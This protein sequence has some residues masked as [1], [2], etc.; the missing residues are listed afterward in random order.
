MRS[1][2]LLITII[3]A[4]LAGIAGAAPAAWAGGTAHVYVGA[5]KCKTC[6]GKVEMGDQYGVWAKSKH[7]KAMETLR[8]TKAKEYGAKK[9]IADPSTAKECVECHTYAYTAPAELKGSKFNAEEGV[10]CEACHGAG[11]DYKKKSIMTDVKQAEANGLVKQSSAVCTKCHNDKSPAYKGFDY[12]TAVK[13]IAHPVP[14]SY[15]PAADTS[16]E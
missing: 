14:D 5:S 16:N 10:S 6:H 8:G 7:A 13:K 11:N 4:L 3:L 1:N 2:A 9:G 15:D 12:A